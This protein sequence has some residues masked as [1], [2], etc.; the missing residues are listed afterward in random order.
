[1]NTNN[2]FI[3]LMNLGTPEQAY[4]Q[5]KELSSSLSDDQHLIRS[6]IFDLHAAIEVELRRIYYHT[7]HTQLFLTDEEEHNLQVEKKFDKM[8]GKLGFMDMFRVLKPILISWPYPEFA[9][10]EEFNTTR[11]Q[12]AHGDLSKVK[13]KNRSPFEDPDCFAEMYFTVWALK[14][15]F[16]KFFSKAVEE[17]LVT[18]KR[19]V[20][21]FGV[22]H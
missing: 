7:F 19:Y 12:A 11:N 9:D 14:Q 6:C 16:T 18:L 10:I 1:M 2:K 17:P 15:C 20:D 5:I 21:K 22:G 8:I 4:E 13:Y 3:D